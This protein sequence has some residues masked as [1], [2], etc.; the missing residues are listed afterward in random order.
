MT[1]DVSDCDFNQMLQIEAGAGDSVKTVKGKPTL[2]L[3]CWQAYYQLVLL[4]VDIP[5]GTQDSNVSV[6]DVSSLRQFT[7][8]KI[9]TDAHCFGCTA[10]SGSSCG[11]SLL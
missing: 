5:D 10:G 3:T 1:R 4:F 8:A 7:G 9:A 2:F 6:F 11:G